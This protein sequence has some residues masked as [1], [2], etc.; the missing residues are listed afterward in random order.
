MFIIFYRFEEYSG[1]STD[2]G[3][4]NTQGVSASATKTEVSQTHEKERDAKIDYLHRE[5]LSTSPHPVIHTIH[6]TYSHQMVAVM[7]IPE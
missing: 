3:L 7:E 6:P 5:V 2:A 1:R 4:K